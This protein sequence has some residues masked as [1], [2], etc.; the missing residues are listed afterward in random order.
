VRAD[1]IKARSA[2]LH[3]WAG[4]ISADFNCRRAEEDLAN[5]GRTIHLCSRRVALARVTPVH[6]R[7]I[8]R[9][10]ARSKTVVNAPALTYETH[11][12]VEHYEA[13]REDIIDPNRHR[14]Q[15]RGLA[16]LVR[17][18]MVAW[19][20]GVSEHSPN[21]SVANCKSAAIDG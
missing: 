4:Y 2:E 18:G 14:Q 3:K 12:L 20:K 19:M 17:K 9:A 10:L 5:T 15:V 8:E 7:T 21:L 1:P 11:A 6:R 13:L 16:L